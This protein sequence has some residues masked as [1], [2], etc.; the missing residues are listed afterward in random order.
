MATRAITRLIAAG[1]ITMA[2]AT[3]QEPVTN[4]LA[5]KADAIAEGRALFAENIRTPGKDVLSGYE[6]VVAITRDDARIAGVRR[7][8]DTFTVQLMDRQEKLHLLTK[9]NLKEITYPR[10]LGCW[11]A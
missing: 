3:G 9:D 6:T 4:P 8:E 11:R 2:T 1:S 7:N 10:Q 5:G